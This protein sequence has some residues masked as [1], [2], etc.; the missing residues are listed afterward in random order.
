MKKDYIG[1][2]EY[3]KEFSDP[4]VIQQI[5]NNGELKCLLKRSNGTVYWVSKSKSS[6]GQ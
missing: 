6:E 5:R 4:L 3:Y 1:A 2:S